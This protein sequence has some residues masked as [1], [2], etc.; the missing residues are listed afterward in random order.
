L[1]PLL[2]AL[3]SGYA[4]GKFMPV[5]WPEY[6]ICV[7][8]S[9][10]VYFLTNIVFSAF[11]ASGIDASNVIFAAIAGVIQSPLLMLGVF[12]AR[13]SVKRNTF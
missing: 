10:V 11:H 13:R 7:P 4:I 2:V 1:I 12:L 3:L 8:V 9:V 5:G 6:A